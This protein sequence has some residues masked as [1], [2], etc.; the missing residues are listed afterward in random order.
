MLLLADTCASD[1]DIQ[2][3]GGPKRAQCGGAKC[4]ESESDR[5]SGGRISKEGV[6]VS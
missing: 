1:T 4:I 2:E 3:G 5:G 6:A